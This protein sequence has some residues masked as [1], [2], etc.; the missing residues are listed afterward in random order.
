MYNTYRLGLITEFMDNSANLENMY[1]K[2][3]KPG[4]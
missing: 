3:K 1:R 2:R 4:Q